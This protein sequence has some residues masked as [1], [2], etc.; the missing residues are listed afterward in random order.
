MNI[1]QG[2][3]HYKLYKSGKLWVAALIVA[4]GLMTVPSV[5]HADENETAPVTIQ[6]DQQSAANTNGSAVKG[7]VKQSNQQTPVTDNGQV[8]SA[9]QQAK[10][11]F[12]NDQDL[13]KQLSDKINLDQQVLGKGTIFH[14]FAKNTKLDADTNG[15]FATDKLV[16]NPDF[17]SRG[18]TPNHTTKDIYYIGDAEK[19]APNGFRTGNNYVIL[20][21]DTN[22]KFNGDQVYVNG[23]R[24]DHLKKA[25]V[26]IAKGYLDIDSELH[27]L[28]DMAD[29]LADQPESANVHKDFNDMNNQVIDVS[30]AD[31]DLIIINID[32][33][34]LSNPQPI[35][36]KGL[37][38][39]N[40]GQAVILN[41]K[42]DQDINWQ[43]QIKLIYDDGTQLS[44]NE[45]HSKPNHVLWNF[46]T[47][48][49][50]INISSGYLMGSVLV[51]NGTINVNVNADGNLIAHDVN[52]RGGESHR[53][54]LW[55]PSFS[56]PV[57][58]T[59]HGDHGQPE[60]PQESTDKPKPSNPGQSTKPE[61]PV[62]PTTPTNPDNHQPEEPTTPDK[63]TTPDKPGKTT[64]PDTPDQPENPDIPNRSEKPTNP[65]TPNTPEEPKNPEKPVEPAKP[66]NPT[67][68]DEPENPTPGQPD[69]PDESAKPVTPDEPAT[70]DHPENPDVPSQPD[71]PTTPT[72]PDT[73]ET[74]DI[75]NRPE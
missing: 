3:N 35:T 32:S 74:P 2:H 43:T 55:A 46:G 41:V 66:E 61:E 64:E 73:P 12:D 23:T 10:T 20:G 29:Y 14:I 54:D 21:D 48:N 63:S 7:D 25:D 1:L 57:P 53:W 19:L 4:T 30:K 51:P 37:S 24:L 47:A 28:S 18:N 45:S 22:V 8:Q 52:I 68:P 9:D 27:K 49:R 60:T 59:P 38:S 62:T 31:D 40:D 65:D 39:K 11:T 5:A 42:G 70:P 72:T 16:D 69:K 56:L 50:T 33:Q 67:K 17:G 6:A 58:V 75:P 36:I 34:K 15:N 26:K 44:P 71:E 13:H